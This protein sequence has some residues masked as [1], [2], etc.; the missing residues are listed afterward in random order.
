MAIPEEVFYDNMSLQMI[1]HL[2][3]VYPVRYT[4]EVLP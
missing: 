3:Q 2:G 1:E 4:K